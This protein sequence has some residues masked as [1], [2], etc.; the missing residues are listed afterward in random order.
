MLTLYGLWSMVCGLTGCAVFHLEQARL[1]ENPLPEFRRVMVAP[2]PATVSGKDLAATNQGWNGVGLAEMFSSELVRFPGFEVIRPEQVL[3]AAQEERLPLSGP[4]QFLK[5]AK[6]L[7]AHVVAVGAIT[8]FQPYYPPRAVMALAVYHFSP[9][10]KERD[11][12]SLEQQGRPFPFYREDPRKPGWS[13]ER[14]YDA[15]ERATRETLKAYSLFRF[16]TKDRAAQDET[17]LYE[18]ESYLRFVMN[19]TIR[20][21]IKVLKA[22]KG[23]SSSAGSEGATATAHE[24]G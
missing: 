2:F 12:V 16:D 4:E 18:P 17:F 5:L 1:P 6:K 21:W 19:Q 3:S 9:S 20:E 11:L 7:G 23:K 15:S 13:T 14:M 24:D 8:E 22:W 10:V